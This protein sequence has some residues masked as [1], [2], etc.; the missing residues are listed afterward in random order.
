[1]IWFVQGDKHH[2]E[3]I[4]ALELG[5]QTVLQCIKLNTIKL[6]KTSHSE[7][8]ILEDFTFMAMKENKQFYFLKKKEHVRKPIQRR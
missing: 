8:L 1:M 7:H 5:I 3:T 4:S 2:D 6:Y